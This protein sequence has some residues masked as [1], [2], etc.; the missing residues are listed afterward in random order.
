MRDFKS[1][2]DIRR[3]LRLRRRPCRGPATRCVKNNG[4]MRAEL[5]LY[6]SPL[7]NRGVYNDEYHRYARTHHAHHIHG[8]GSRVRV[9]V[10]LNARITVYPTRLI[11]SKRPLPTPCAL[12]HPSLYSRLYWRTECTKDISR[13]QLA[14]SSSRS[15]TGVRRLC[16][17]ARAARHPCLDRFNAAPRSL[18]ARSSAARRLNRIR[19]AKRLCLTL[20]LV[21]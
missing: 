18:P 4:R 15:R 1:C 19:S 8:L 6:V 3:T 21:W 16:I 2:E 13:S 12:T 14:A 11:R 20:V 17:A 10:S 7:A 9:P 5:H